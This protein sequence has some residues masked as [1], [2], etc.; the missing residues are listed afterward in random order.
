MNDYYD[1]TIENS[2]LNGGPAGSNQNPI[3]SD[4]QFGD[5]QDCKNW[6][7]RNN[8]MIGAVLWG[9]NLGGINGGAAASTVKNN[10]FSIGSPGF[11]NS[12]CIATFTYNIWETGGTGCGG[13]PALTGSVSYV[14][15]SSNPTFD[16]HLNAGSFGLAAGDPGSFPTTDYDGQLRPIPAATSPDIGADER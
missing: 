13:S 1:V 8:S 9:C 15:R 4:D 12:E 5:V 10:I 11:I 14:D 16:L 6:V 3:S 7:V 2:M